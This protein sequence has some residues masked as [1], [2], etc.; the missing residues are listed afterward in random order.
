[1]FCI[2]EQ[3]FPCYLTR[4]LICLLY[5][6]AFLHAFF[7]ILYKHQGNV[8]Y[9]IILN[10]QFQRKMEISCHGHYKMMIH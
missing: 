9:C 10:L 4:F 1:M 2:T 3:W 6:S 8:K 5:F 7:G